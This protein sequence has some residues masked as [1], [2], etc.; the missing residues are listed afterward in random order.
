[1]KV[2]IIIG[3]RTGNG[4]RTLSNMKQEW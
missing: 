4:A 2:L 3:H 1:M